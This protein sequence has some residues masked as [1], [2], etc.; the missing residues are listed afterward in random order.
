[1]GGA[2]WWFFSHLRDDR[3][4]LHSSMSPEELLTKVALRVSPKPPWQD[5]ALSSLPLKSNFLP[6]DS[7]EAFVADF[8]DRGDLA[9]GSRGLW[10]R[11]GVTHVWYE[12]ATGYGAPARWIPRLIGEV[13]LASDGG[14]TVTYRVRMMHYSQ[15]LS[16]IVGLGLGALFVGMG[17]ALLLTTV[18]I[19]GGLVALGVGTL[20][21]VVSLRQSR[22]ATH[23]VQPMAHYLEQSIQR[24][25]QG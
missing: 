17:M 25:A 20:L 4:T 14:S 8:E 2:L 5:E 13:A 18:S 19:G 16:W 12:V 23:L 3:K 11:V 1:M 7:F 9:M 10:G 21:I 22:R 6:E 24:F 15:V